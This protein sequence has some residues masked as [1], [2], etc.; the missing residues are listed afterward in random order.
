M[1]KLLYFLNLFFLFFHLEQFVDVVFVSNMLDQQ[2]VKKVDRSDVVICVKDHPVIGKWKIRLKHK[3]H[4]VN[5]C[6]YFSHGSNFAETNKKKINLFFKIIFFS[7]VN[8]IYLYPIVQRCCCLCS[9]MIIISV[10]H[11]H[12][13]WSYLYTSIQRHFYRYFSASW[14]PNLQFSSV[15]SSLQTVSNFI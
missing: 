8:P 3:F 15:Y 9:S 11:A 13:F 1:S 6:L 10:V 14:S 12:L 2:E 4:F 5:C 7:V